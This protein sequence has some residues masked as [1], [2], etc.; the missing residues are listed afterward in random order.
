[1]QLRDLFRSEDDLS[2]LSTDERDKRIVKQRRG[3]FNAVDKLLDDLG[4]A[5]YAEKRLQDVHP[6]LQWIGR[7]FRE[8]ENVTSKLFDDLFDHASGVSHGDHVIK[9]E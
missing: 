3:L 9:K 8:Y 1:L 2:A 6:D 7:Q 4:A 5:A